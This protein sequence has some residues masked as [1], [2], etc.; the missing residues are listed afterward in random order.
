M[1][2]YVAQS[3]AVRFFVILNFVYS[4][5]EKNMSILST[6]TE[7]TMRKIALVRGSLEWAAF[8]WA[9]V[10]LMVNTKLTEI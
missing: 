8:T 5:V 10:S 1:K 4:R 3:S 7:P 6:L 9:P 2:G